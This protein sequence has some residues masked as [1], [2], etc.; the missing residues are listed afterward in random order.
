MTFEIPQK[1]YTCDAIRPHHHLMIVPSQACPASCHYC[2]SPNADGLLMSQETVGAISRWVNSF[3]RE[4]D[5]EIT[6]HGGEPLVAGMEFFRRALPLLRG[7]LSPRQMRF[8]MQS[9][10][11]LLSDDLC[12]IFREHNVS[13]GTSLDGPKAI[14]D[15]QRGSGYFDRTM[16][17]IGI[18]RRRGLNI[19]C[20]CTFTNQSLPYI[21]EIFDFF[22]HEGLD[23]SIHAEDHGRLLVELLDRYLQKKI[24]TRVNTLDA[25]C[26]SVAAGYSGICTF[27]DCLGGYLAVGPDGTIYPCQRFVGMSRYRLGS[28][29]DDASQKSFM[30]SPIWMWLLER[31]EHILEE[32]SG[33]PHFEYCQ[34][35]CPY[36]TLASTEGR[37][38][39]TGRDPHCQ[40]YKSFFDY[41][42]DRALS[43]VFSHANLKAVIK[44]NNPQVGLLMKGRLIE[45]MRG[46]P[47]PSECT[48]YALQ[49]LAATALAATG[50]PSEAARMFN[51]LNMTTDLERA[52]KSMQFLDD[53][54]KIPST[55][56]NNLYLHVT[57][58]C[59]LEC[60]HCYAKA[61]RSRQGELSAEETILL[62]RE[63]AEQGFNK[64]VI[65][66]GEPLAHSQK[67]ELLERLAL[68]RA[69]VKPMLTTLRTSLCLSL[70]DNELEQIAN[71]AD[72]IIVSV[73][74]DRK[75]HDARR[76][77]GSY[78]CMVANIRSFMKKNGTAQVALASVLPLQ[79]INGSPGIAVRTLA[80]ELG[81]RRVQFRPILPLGRAS[82]NVPDVFVD[83]LWGHIDPRD[84]VGYGFIPKS[85]CGI[86]Q[87]LYVE[88]DGKVYP[89]YAWHGEQWLLGNALGKGGLKEITD[90]H[91]FQDLR[92]HTVDS[93][94]KC[95]TCTLRY[96]CGGACRAW[97]RHNPS[98]QVDLDEPPSDCSQ[99][100]AR[101][102]S[103][104]SSA[105]DFVGITRM[106]WQ[107]AGLPMPDTNPT[108]T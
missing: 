30:L 106:Q 102:L 105:M 43:E 3:D 67:D 95:G 72:Q 4:S 35:G 26:Q 32:C 36:N 40:A 74:G 23:I 83:T 104:L 107:E 14:N 84:V 50:S 2:F 10:L 20:I 25:M 54:L 75:T 80:A 92:R 64:A 68:L 58:Y 16:A 11:W 45:L 73:D 70:R 41:V 59:P 29:H 62:I 82:E 90:S 5:L 63:A 89:C 52:Q 21:G 96:L 7:S 76:G 47:H 8:S 85:T 93:N 108:N 55:R 66:G 12:S 78:D 57:F 51:R 6:F 103:L 13:L 17:G 33:C 99:L 34:G 9:N 88:P 86:G 91:A 19:G 81:I 60:S 48:R 98:A 77:E 69:M 27:G 79:Q 65:T 31:K 87:N 15:P 53:Y 37:F 100:H 28:V 46:G 42:I 38:S 49:L 44:H 1:Q 22:V 24:S 101:A 39:I 56:L 94:R 71:C 61:G 97:N 18:A